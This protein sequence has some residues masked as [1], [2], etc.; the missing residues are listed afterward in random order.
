M[1]LSRRKQ[2]A[3]EREVGRVSQVFAS[4]LPSGKVFS[5]S[6]GRQAAAGHSLSSAW[7]HVVAVKSGQRLT[8]YLDGE[9][10]S[11]S[12]DFEAAG[13]DLTT[14]VPPRIGAGANGTFNGRLADVRIYRRTLNATEIAQLSTPPSPR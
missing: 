5:F 8:L 1:P 6:E 7:H 4:T 3:P 14:N 11:Q 12:P 9:R 2:I 10:V 13:Y